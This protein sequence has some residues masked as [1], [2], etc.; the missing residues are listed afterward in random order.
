MS[1]ASSYPPSPPFPVYYTHNAWALA[2][3]LCLRTVGKFVKV[4]EHTLWAFYIGLAD[5]QCLDHPES[6]SVSTLIIEVL[7]PRKCVISLRACDPSARR[8][9]WEVVEDPEIPT[10]EVKMATTGLDP[11]GRCQVVSMGFED[12][13]RL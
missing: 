13:A 11:E 7:Y 4:G 6:R 12:L 9:Y 3:W 2:R 5:G 10:G 8:V 1:S